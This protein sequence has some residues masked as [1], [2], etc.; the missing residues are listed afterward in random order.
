MNRL[1]WYLIS[2]VAWS[3]SSSRL[4]TESSLRKLWIRVVVVSCCWNS[5]GSG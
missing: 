1:Q 2:L 3:L 4:V 5:C